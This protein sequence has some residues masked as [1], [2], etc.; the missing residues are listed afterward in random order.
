MA[1]LRRIWGRTLLASVL[2]ALLALPLGP[3]GSAHA[4]GA[5]TIRD[6]ANLFTSAG[7]ARITQAAQGAPFDVL[8]ITN[9]Q[10]FSSKAAW[11]SW[12]RSQASGQNTVTIGLHFVPHQNNV[13]AVP[14]SNT[15]LSQSQ[16]DQGVAQVL[17]TF[18]NNQPGHVTAGVTQLI[19]T[20]KS[21]SSAQPSS[22]GTSF[23][24]VIPLIVL[25]ILA[26]FALRLFGRRRRVMGY[27]PGMG[28]PYGPYGG[29]YGPGYGGWGSGGRGF[30]GGLLGG[31][32]GAWIGNQI[33]GNRGDG[34]V[35]AGGFDPNATGPTDTPNAD[36]PGDWTGPGDTG[37]ADAGGGWSGADA[38]G[39]SGG[40]SGSSGW[41]N[42]S[43][44]SGGGWT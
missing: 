27:G 32:G 8:V 35:Y 6:D 2:L 34:N 10:S 4:A 30:L 11:Q 24:W 14:G 5:A 38:G 19:Q 40:D 36:A 17:P 43:G 3:L 20:Y 44:D 28:G 13:Y 26:F 41:D 31:L 1:P 18:N 23:G 29:G 33:F 37:S 25:L 9:A 22:G 21:T 15:G 42:S 12:L 16:A 39:W 7:R